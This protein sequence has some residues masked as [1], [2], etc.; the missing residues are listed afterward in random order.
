MNIKKGEKILYLLI[1]VV[2]ISLIVFCFLS[3]LNYM[4]EYKYHIDENF[5]HADLVHSYK[6]RKIE[7]ETITGYL[8]VFIAYL[9][10][11][12]SYFL[13]RLFFRKR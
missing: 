12:T 9:I 1:A 8:K 13:Y 3:L 11:I 5:D 7:I 2:S 4:V 10:M 6:S